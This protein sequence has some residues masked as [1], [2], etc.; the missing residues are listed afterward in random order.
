[1]C[2]GGVLSID[3]KK[4]KSI[5]IM[6]PTFLPWLGYFSLID[7]VDEFVFFDHVQFEKRSWQQRNKIRTYDS[8]IWLSVP[9]SSKG[10]QS[11]SIK[12]AEIMYEGKRSPLAKIMSSIDVNYKK[13]PF[14]TEY[15]QELMS[16][17]LQEPKYISDL[18]QT[19]I[20]WICEKLEIT[21]SFKR[22][23]NL[24]V[25]GSKADLLVNICES[26][27]ATHYISPPG[28]KIYLDESTAFQDA[29]VELSYFS[30]THP[31][32]MQLHG[33][34]VPYMSVL[35]LLFN[36]GPKSSEIMRMGR[37]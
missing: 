18:N 2:G 10:K 31:S 4:N 24:D 14:Y 13:S 11:Q 8:E 12:D 35:D 9:V 16:I 20:R 15:S 3:Q 5:A 1:M 22:S 26:Q 27:E 19:L 7:T 29:G 6:Q 23:S 30:Y 25:N 37:S 21:T 32:Y 36:V 28:S 33:D 17:F 34:F